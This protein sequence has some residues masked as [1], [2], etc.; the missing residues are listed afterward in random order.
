MEG[1]WR[2]HDSTVEER[3]SVEKKDVTL[4]EKEE[5]EGRRGAKQL[6]YP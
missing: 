1:Y 4:V 6:A 3:E 5:E 2:I